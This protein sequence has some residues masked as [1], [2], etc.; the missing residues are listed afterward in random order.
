MRRAAAIVLGTLTGTAL[1]V[2]AKLGNATPGDDPV[3]AGDGGVVVGGPGVA[4]SGGARTTAPGKSPAPGGK[5]P[6]GGPT[7]KA[8]TG[9]PTTPGQTPAPP[10]TTPRPP[11]TTPP[12]AG[13][14]DGTYQ[15]QAQV[16]GGRFGT[17]SMSV[18]VSGGRITGISAREDGGETNCYH[19]ACNTLKPEALSAQSADVAS[20]SGATYTSSAFKAAL[21]AILNTANA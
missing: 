6:T 8:P 7:T 16:R 4:V 18:T 19:G 12:P 20:V 3:L 2:G 14:K 15:A 21:T 1:M 13:P 9:A 5:T 11:P 10:R 17:L